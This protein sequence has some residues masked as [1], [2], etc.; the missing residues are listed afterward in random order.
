MPVGAATVA[1]EFAGTLM[2]RFAPPLILYVIVIAKFCG[3]VNV[4]LGEVP[5]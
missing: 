3:L 4:I 5:F 2:V 1:D